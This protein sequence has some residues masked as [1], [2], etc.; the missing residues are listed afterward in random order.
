MFRSTLQS[1]DPDGQVKDLPPCGPPPG[2]PRDSEPS[3]ENGPESGNEQVS[4]Y[5]VYLLGRGEADLGEHGLPVPLTGAWWLHR[6]NR[7]YQE[8]GSFST[9]AECKADGTTC[10][11]GGQLQGEG[12]R[13]R[14][15]DKRKAQRQSGGLAKYQQQEVAHAYDVAAVFSSL[16]PLVGSHVDSPHDGHDDQS[17]AAVDLAHGI[18]SLRGE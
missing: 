10:K 2:T 16:C 7:T 1:R 11:E 13:E 18:P 12:E 14:G 9:I 3:R 4:S 8:L 17:A 15:E 6:A 5:C